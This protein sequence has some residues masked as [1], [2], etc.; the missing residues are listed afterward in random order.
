V[1]STIVGVV[2][3]VI[4]CYLYIFFCRNTSVVQLKQLRSE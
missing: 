2:I 4:S 1:I 3:S